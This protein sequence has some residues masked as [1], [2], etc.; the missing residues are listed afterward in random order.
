MCWMM[1]GVKKEKELR[2][3]DEVLAQEEA[4]LLSRE[5]GCADDMKSLCMSNCLAQIRV[6]LIGEIGRPL[7]LVLRPGKCSI[8]LLVV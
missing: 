6:H 8:T 7:G 2:A 3:E 1:V 4:P 5:T